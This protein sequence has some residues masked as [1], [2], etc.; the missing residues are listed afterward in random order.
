[1]QS[2]SIPFLDLRISQAEK[3]ELMT[4]VESVF[5]SGQLVGGP[6][7]ESFEAEIAQYVGRGHCCAVGS[8]STALYLALLAVGI[9]SGDEVITTSL[10]WIAT[11][12]AIALAG[13]TPVFADIDES[14]NI[15]PLSVGRLITKKTKAVVVVDYTGKLADYKSLIEICEPHGIDVVEDGSQAFGSRR[16]GVYC[17]AYGVISAISHNPMKVYAATGE[18]G[19][20]LMDSPELKSRL[21]ILRYNGTVNKEYLVQPS[22]NGRMDAMQAAILRCRLPYV[23]DIINRRQKNAAIYMERLKRAEIRLPLVERNETHAFYTY[24]VRVRER[25]ELAKFLRENRIEVKIQHPILMP[26]QTPYQTCRREMK[27]AG[28]IRDRIL[29]LPVHEKLSA[30]DIHHVCDL[31]HAFYDKP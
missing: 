10:S 22:V 7:V 25:D 15:D 23:K 9:G 24:T 16:D 18:A 4:V 28:S 30:S 26:E 13:A 17:G 5:D 1:M 21:D 29:C 14:L 19:S 20:I 27:L 6:E 31:V 8:G 3:A 12:N 11:A 2:R